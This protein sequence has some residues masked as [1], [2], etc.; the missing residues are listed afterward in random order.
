MKIKF[1]MII[2]MII[3]ALAILSIPILFIGSC[4]SLVGSS[5]SEVDD[6]SAEA[7]LAMIYFFA[8]FGLLSII[9]G[10]F[11]PTKI[12]LII[13]FLGV[14]IYGLMNLGK[15]DL[16]LYYS[17]AS[18]I[19]GGYYI[20]DMIYSIKY[21]KKKKIIEEEVMASDK[22]KEVKEMKTIEVES[23]LLWKDYKNI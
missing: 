5:L 9:V 16:V 22:A 2:R 21:K 1:L 7:G 4:V 19:V 8:A 10:R 14:G 13:G 12:I 23:D 18:L 17:I 3:G 11:I 20:F 15:L 6:P